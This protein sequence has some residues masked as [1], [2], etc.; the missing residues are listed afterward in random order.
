ML[1]EATRHRL[2]WE[3]L[4]L[5][6]G[7]LQMS[8]VAVSLGSLLAFGLYPVAYLFVIAATTTTVASRLIYHGRSSPLLK[9]Q[10]RD[11]KTR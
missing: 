6:L 8:L 9:E 1:T 11:D 10:N 7:W 2:V 5:F 4:R 3:W